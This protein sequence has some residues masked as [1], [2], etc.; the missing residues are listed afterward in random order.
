MKRGTPDGTIGDGDVV[1]I[2]GSRG[3][4]TENVIDKCWRSLSWRLPR[5]TEKQIWYLK[6]HI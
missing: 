5:V 1:L 3:V 4:R 2:K 6:L